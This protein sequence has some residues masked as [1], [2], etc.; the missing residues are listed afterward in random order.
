MNKT[1]FIITFNNIINGVVVSDDDFN[2]TLGI[3]SLQGIIYSEFEVDNSKSQHQNILLALLQKT[4][5]FYTVY[6]GQ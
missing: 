5:G 6:L 3:L 1:E 2:K 4:I